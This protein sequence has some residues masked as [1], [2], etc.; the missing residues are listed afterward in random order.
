MCLI[1]QRLV[2][3]LVLYVALRWA[4]GCEAATARLTLVENGQSPYTI[5]HAAKAS[6]NTILAAQEL[7]DYLK[8]IASVEL[9]IALDTAP[10]GP[11]EILVGDST[12]L[13][14]LPTSIDFA[15]VG[16][17]GFTLRTVGPHLVIA[18]GGEL[19]NLY[20]VYT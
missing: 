11:H 6:E 18:S 17:Q 1:Q 7:R 4:S 3:F 10:M 5:V 19:G 12:H 13:R 20:G 14:Q 16:A 9:L 8:R 15:K 2:V